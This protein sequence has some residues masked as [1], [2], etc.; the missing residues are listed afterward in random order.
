MMYK[1]IKG[2][3]ANKKILTS[4]WRQCLY[5]IYTFLKAAYSLYILYFATDLPP[6]VQKTF[7]EQLGLVQYLVLTLYL[8]YAI[9]FLIRM[10]SFMVKKE[11]LIIGVTSNTLAS[12]QKMGVFFLNIGYIVVSIAI[13]GTLLLSLA[14]SKGFSGVQEGYA[15]A[16]ALFF[17]IIA[18]VLIEFGN[19]KNATN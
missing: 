15:V 9:Y 3:Y 14:S 6:E 16:I 8:A 13:I 10:H 18:I 7:I 4:I 19:I 11:A 5:S 2:Y 12:G 17:S 1:N